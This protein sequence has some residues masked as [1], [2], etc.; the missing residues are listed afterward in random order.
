MAPGVGRRLAE[1]EGQL[2]TLVAELALAR[3][4]RREEIAAV[5]RTSLREVPDQPAV[6]S[7]SEIAAEVAREVRAALGE[8]I[9]AALREVVA[10]ARA[11]ATPASA[12]VTSA[13]PSSGLAPTTEMALAAAA[14]SAAL[15][16]A[17]I[18]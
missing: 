3:V 16:T 11:D 2:A 9:R 8:D 4:Q 10:E 18:V 1:I 12:V 6:P 13:A 14:P 17:P 7:V 15:S 5:R